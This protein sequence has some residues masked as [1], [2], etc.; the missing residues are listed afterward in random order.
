[1]E[2]IKT[3]SGDYT[4]KYNNK[5]IHSSY[6]PIKEASRFA[7]GINLEDFKGNSK[8]IIY[9]LGLGYHIKEIKKLLNDDF[10]LII[11][12]NNL[13]VLKLCR[14]IN[15]SIFQDANIKVITPKD[16]EFLELLSKELKESKDII[17][18]KNSLEF[19]KVDDIELYKLLTN[20][21][22]VRESI[23]RDRELLIANYNENLKRDYKKIDEFIKINDLSNKKVVIVA[24]GPS[25]DEDINM[26]KKVQR[27]FYI[28]AVGSAL[29]ILMNNNIK[30]DALVIIDGKPWVKNQIEGYENE[31]I[32]L[33]YLSTASRW[34]TENYKG[35][36]YMFYNGLE[37]KN[38]VETG[39]TVAIAA[40]SVAVL[41]NTK[42]MIFLGQDLAIINN[43]T[44]N[45]TFNDMYEDF[46][47]E[48]GSNDKAPK[49][50]SVS[51][52]ML[53]T[54]TGYL[55]FKD[56]IEKLI[57]KNK[58]INF[59][60]CSHGAYIEGAENMPFGEVINKLGGSY[61]E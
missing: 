31:D 25:L 28:I 52:E 14:Q 53:E 55:I 4:I 23:K 7:T 34:M 39:K 19:L 12:E 26:L 56:G 24:S 50:K 54:K 37:D 57:Q 33:L 46:T 58:Q 17:I 22:E 49:V 48:V 44:H 29:R 6:D 20:F 2:L 15:P 5:F 10:E 41:C 13:E 45:S 42:I 16:K 1:M 60:N 11:F 40:M 3:R 18:Y 27:E 32:P 47:S 36:K 51:G 38:T 59:Y 61:G 43:K 30:P 35:P 9:G 21:Y 8:L